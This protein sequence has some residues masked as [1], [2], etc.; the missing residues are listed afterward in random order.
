MDFLAAL[1]VFTMILL[2]LLWVWGQVKTDISVQAATAERRERAL[3]ISEVLV[4]SQG[5]PTYWYTLNVTT[6]DV[7][8]LGLA[9][10]DHVLMRE[11]LEAV[12]EANYSILKSVMGLGRE[13]FTLTVTSNYTGDANTEYEIGE[14]VPENPYQLVYRR[15]AVLDDKP[16]EVSLKV[17]Y[18]V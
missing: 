17:S 5:K 14:S 6:N 11:K 2:S 15:L 16:V 8:V 4:S 12:Q 1:V 7:D 9:G 18:D 13:D 3:R 10:Q